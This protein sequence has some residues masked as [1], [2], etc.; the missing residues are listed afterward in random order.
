MLFRSLLLMIPT[1]IGMTIVVFVIIRIAPGRPEELMA[2]G[3]G[4]EV[5]MAEGGRDR[6]LELMRERMGLTGPIH[7][8]YLKWMSKVVRLDFSD[9]LIQRRPVMEMMKERVGI[10]ILLNVLSTLLVYFVSIPIGLIAAKYRERGGAGRFVFDT[11][12]GLALLV[13][14]SLPAIF[15][16]TLLIVLLGDGGQLSQH[17]RMLQADD[18]NAAGVL[19]HLV[20]PIGGFTSEGSDRL[21]LFGYLVDIARHMLL[22]VI[23]LT[24]GS[25]AFMS[26]QV[27]TSLLENLRQ[28]YVRTARAKGLR[29]RSV[30]YVHALRNSL[31]PML[32]LMTG[33]LPSMIG[34]SII[35]EQKIGRASCRERV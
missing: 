14:Y 23:T 7:M 29:E 19:K 13:M 18:P 20:M 3:E 16:G 2:R 32:T 10:T 22:P 34:G 21:T 25:L 31:L 24:L 35:V 30:V 33:I 6:N 12:S 15:V 27:R 4:G 1:L 17:V 28:D 26:K 5:Q 8:Q 9:S 11:S